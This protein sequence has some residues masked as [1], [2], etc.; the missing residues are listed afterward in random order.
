L[1]PPYG[2]DAVGV[3]DLR[4]GVIIERCG[5]GAQQERPDEV[6]AA[7]LAFLGSLDAAA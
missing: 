6:N 3:T 4:E 7:L 5:H 1:A 2:V